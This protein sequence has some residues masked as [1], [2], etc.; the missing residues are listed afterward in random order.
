MFDV[1]FVLGMLFFSTMC[2]AEQ[3]SENGRPFG[4]PESG[5]NADRK[6]RLAGTDSID[7][8]GVES[9]WITPKLRS[10]G[11]EHLRGGM[12]GVHN[13]ITYQFRARSK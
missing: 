4:R 8:G 1:P 13:V 7:G 12:Q 2:L 5:E 10:S 6:F 3:A 11:D 9:A